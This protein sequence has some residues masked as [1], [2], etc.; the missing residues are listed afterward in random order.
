MYVNPTCLVF[1][2][3]IIQVAYFIY[4]LKLMCKQA[5]L[6]VAKNTKYYLVFVSV[7]SMKNSQRNSVK[8]IWHSYEVL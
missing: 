3:N 2:V 6:A 8:N 1:K 7:T 5:C 4:N